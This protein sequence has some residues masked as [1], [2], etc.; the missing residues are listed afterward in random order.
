MPDP[1]SN[2]EV[3]VDAAMQSCIE[4]FGD[5]TSDDGVGKVTY[6]HVSGASYALDG[7]F[8]AAS[9]TVGIENGAEV[10]SYQPVFSTRLSLMQEAPGRRDTLLIR[11]TLY[12]VVEPTFDGQG[13]V[14]LRLAEQ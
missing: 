11:G 2:W 9:E 13:T 1:R 4:V 12:R 10:V 7:I 3:N 6:T 8:E 14:T 5:G